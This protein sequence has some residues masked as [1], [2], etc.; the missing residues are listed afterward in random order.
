MT[1]TA[2]IIEGTTC[3]LCPTGTLPVTNTKCEIQYQLQACACAN[4]L[5]DC[6]CAIYSGGNADGVTPP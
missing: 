4:N 6:L 1:D 5:A 2:E 3:G